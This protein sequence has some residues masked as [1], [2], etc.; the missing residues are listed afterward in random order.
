MKALTFSDFKQYL[1]KYWRAHDLH[2]VN[3]Q[4]GKQT[5]LTLSKITFQNG[6]RDCDLTRTA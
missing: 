5:R 4:T 6:L 1:G 3:H 2:M